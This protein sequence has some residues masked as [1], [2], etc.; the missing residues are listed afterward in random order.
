[1]LNA[2]KDAT[3]TF[4]RV[5]ER[6]LGDIL[7][8]Q[9]DNVRRAIELLIYAKQQNRTVHVVGMGRSGLAG[10][11][12]ADMLK[13]RGIKTSVIGD[14]LAKP[15]GR[16]DLVFAF[17]GSGW[18][19]TTAMYAEMCIRRGATLVAFTATP[20]SKIDRLADFSIY[21][22]GKPVLDSMDYVLRKIIGKYKSPLAPMG[23][24]TEF[25]ALVF[26]AALAISVEVSEPSETFRNVVESIIDVCK[27]SL[28]KLLL[29]SRRIRGFIDNYI[30]AKKENRTC[31]FAGLGLLEHITKMVAIRFQ[32]L[33]IDVG[34]ASEWI[35]RK[36]GDILTVVSG[37]GEASIP[38]I[39]VE[40]GR[41]T[42]M[43]I[44]SVVGNEDGTI[45]RESDIY[46]VLEDIEQ[47]KK[48]F[49]VGVEES[50]DFIPAFEIATLM[51]FEA[52]VA[53][54]A[55]RFGLTEEIMRSYHA[56]IE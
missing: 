25:S 23:S 26:G 14:I 16:E 36:P 34:N 38:K 49:A 8:R 46:L 41:K 19:S 21:L 51:T 2:F 53:E 39:L 50:K 7:N 48:Y 15:V 17:S 45:A 10:R 1:L 5:T 24:I 4:I 35:F 13:L 54:L 37:S 9:W 20:K 44:L 33:G 18:T 6:A 3:L 52:I 22:P 55:Y 30:R 32:H 11:F 47:R 40:E 29:E 12:F 42:G 31:F 27:K 43:V 56:N 28:D